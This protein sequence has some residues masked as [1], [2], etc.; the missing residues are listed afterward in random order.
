M[1]VILFTIIFIMI[2]FIYYRTCTVCD[3]IKQ[4]GYADPYSIGLQA[5]ALNRM[6]RWNL[7]HSRH[8][9]SINNII[10]PP[11]ERQCYYSQY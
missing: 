10:V 11:L 7:Y 4:E 2:L 6:A 1:N 3:N 8:T 9:S 5:K